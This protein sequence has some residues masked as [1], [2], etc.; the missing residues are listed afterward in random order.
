MKAL[1]FDK[2]KTDWESSKVVDLLDVP[3]PVNN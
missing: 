1:I 3:K 2:L